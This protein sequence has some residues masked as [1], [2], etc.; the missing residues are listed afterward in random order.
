MKRMHILPLSLA[1]AAA[2]SASA[3]SYDGPYYLPG[4]G[5][6]YVGMPATMNAPLSEPTIVTQAYQSRLRI[7]NAEVASIKAGAQNYNVSNRIQEDAGELDLVSFMGVGNA[8]D[9]TVRDFE[10]GSYQLGDLAPKKTWYNTR[11]LAAHPNWRGHDNLPLAVYNQWDCPL[12]TEA[13]PHLL[14][15]Y[16]VVT[17]DFGNPHEGLVV[18]D[19]SFPLVRSLACDPDAELSIVL[20]V[21]DDDHKEVMTTYETLFSVCELPVVKQENDYEIVRLSM[22]FKKPI[23]INTPFDVTI[24]GLSGGNQIWPLRAVDSHGIFPSHTTYSVFIGDDDDAPET[25]VDP[26]TDVVINVDGYFNYI[27]TWGWWDGKYE[28]GEVV[29]SA[30]LVQIYYDPASPDWPGDYF[31]GEAAFP[32]ECTFGSGDISIAEMPDWISSVS[33]DDSQW[34]EY[35]CVQISLSADA[36]PKGETG[37]NGKVVLVTADHASYYTIYLR[38]GGAWFDMGDLEGIDAPLAPEVAT[39]STILNFDLQG[40]AIREPRRGQPYISGGKVRVF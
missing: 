35:G 25:F 3:Q 5:M 12:T 39:P 7:R 6:Y 29:G 20:S 2:A 32:I 38:Q 13:D 16:D 8:F 40:R 23:V 22:P 10:G 37:R 31:M 9:L 24:S 34:E 33:Y 30:D 28:R 26:S 27:G 18:S 36:L 1:L 21:W 14:S 11:L 19:V 15:G 4:D 17:V